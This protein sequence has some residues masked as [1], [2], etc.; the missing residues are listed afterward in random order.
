M[1]KVDDSY[2]DLEVAAS[3]YWA[4]CEEAE[5]IARQ[6]Y[7]DDQE[8]HITANYATIQE[9]KANGKVVSFV[10]RFEVRLIAAEG[11]S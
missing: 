5:Q 1:N 8:I 4:A 3:D 7:G 6:F 11:A 10:C 2:L 9:R